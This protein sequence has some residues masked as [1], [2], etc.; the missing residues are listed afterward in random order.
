ME[1]QIALEIELDGNRAEARESEVRREVF[2]NGP[3]NV[4]EAGLSRKQMAFQN[5]RKIHEQKPE[6]RNLKPEKKK[7]ARI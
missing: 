5:G 1:S 6:T 2:L 7:T 4:V 3:H